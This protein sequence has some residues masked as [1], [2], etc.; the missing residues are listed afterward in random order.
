MTNRPAPLVVAPEGDR[1]LRITR[2]FHAPQRLVWRAFTEAELIPKWLWARD[3]PMIECEQDLREGG[4]LRWVWD[5]GA[6]GTMAVSGRFVEI[7]APHRIVHTE[8]FDEDWT[9]GETVVT[10]ILR[11]DG[12][13]T[14]MEMTVLYSSTEARDNA[15]RTP[16][17]EGMEEGYARLDGLFAAG[18]L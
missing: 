18:R 8:L 6:R 11:A 7:E 13:A 16:M 5:L 10:T 15:A 9:G 3:S 1:A 4:A 17:T 12:D 2:R 14:E